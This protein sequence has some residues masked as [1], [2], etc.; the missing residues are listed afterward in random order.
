[1]ESNYLSLEIFPGKGVGSYLLGST[2][3]AILKQLDFSYSKRDFVDTIGIEAESIT[4]FFSKETEELICISL[5]KNFKG[6]I[7]NSIGIGSTLAQLNNV[8]KNI[9]HYDFE[10]DEY[11]IEGARF[12]VNHPG[13]NGEHEE[14]IENIGVCI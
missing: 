12:I 6:M 4:F 13:S 14:L 11:I 9:M 8:F 5:S 7:A 1:M 3:S 2:L 10:N